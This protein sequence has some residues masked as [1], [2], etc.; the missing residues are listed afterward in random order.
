[1]SQGQ[2]DRINNIK[3]LIEKVGGLHLKSNDK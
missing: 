3:D 1:M 2:L